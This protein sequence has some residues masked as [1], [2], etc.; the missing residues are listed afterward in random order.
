MITASICD[1][2]EAP[3]ANFITRRHRLWARGV[4]RAAAD[5][6]N[7]A[8]EKLLRL[9]SDDRWDLLEQIADE[10]PEHHRTVRGRRVRGLNVSD[11]LATARMAAG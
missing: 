11:A 1:R 7:L 5:R 10:T 8:G 6:E 9:L 3:V 4:A 2:D